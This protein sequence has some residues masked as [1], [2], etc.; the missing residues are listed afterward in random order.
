MKKLK[1]TLLIIFLI[2]LLYSCDN[3]ENFP[4]KN[5]SDAINYSEIKLDAIRNISKLEEKINSNVALE[6]EISK[7]FTIKEQSYSKQVKFTEQLNFKI[8]LA[9]HYNIKEATFMLAFYQDLA[10]SYDKDIFNLLDSK[11]KVLNKTS[12]PSNFKQEVNLLFDIIEETTSKIYPILYKENTL[13]SKGTG[14][15]SCMGGKGKDIGRGIAT[16]AIG[17]AIAGAYTGATGGTV[18]L[19]GIGTITGAVGELCLEVL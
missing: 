7:Y 13:Y 8:S 3:K 1:F 15:W 14:F 16:G 12:F 10:N 6:N 19:P 4:E 18:A 17:G 11:R 9:P 5:L 2:K